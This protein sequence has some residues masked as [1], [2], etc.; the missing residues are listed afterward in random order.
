MAQDEL[1]LFHSRVYGKPFSGN[2]PH[3]ENDEPSARVQDKDSKQEDDGLGYY[4]DGAKR[5]LRDEQIAMFRH[6]EIQSLLRERRQAREKTTSEY[7]DVPRSKEIED[8][9]WGVQE[10]QDG[11]LME[12]EGE[13]TDD[14]EE[15]ARFLEAERKEMEL[16]ASRQKKKGAKFQTPKGKASTRRIVREMD[17]VLSTN[18]DL[19]YG[20]GPDDMTNAAEVADLHITQG[21]RGSR[22]PGSNGTVAGKRIWW[23]V[24]GA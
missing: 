2:L 4:D 12:E 9:L 1:L 6:S 10:M 16:A 11:Q 24:L 21:V 7:K 8:G 19:D 22:G 23:P 14:D 13:I 18:D 15:Y 5:T 17:A 20:E 3:P